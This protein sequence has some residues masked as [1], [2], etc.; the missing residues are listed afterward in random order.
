L[1]PVFE[2]IVDLITSG[3]G[4]IGS[5]RRAPFPERGANASLGDVAALAGMLAAIFALAPLFE[6]AGES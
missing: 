2:F 3:L 1:S 5:K 6:S 4:G